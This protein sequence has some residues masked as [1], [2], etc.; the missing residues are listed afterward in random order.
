MVRRKQLRTMRIRTIKKIDYYRK[1]DSLKYDCSKFINEVCKKQWDTCKKIYMENIKKNP[2]NSNEYELRFMSDGYRGFNRKLEDGLDYFFSKKDFPMINIFTKLWDRCVKRTEDPF[3]YV[4]DPDD[5]FIDIKNR[6]LYEEED[7]NSSDDDDEEDEN[8]SDDDDEEDENSSDDDEEDFE[9]CIYK[10]KKIY[11]EKQDFLRE[12]WDEVRYFSRDLIRMRCDL[13]NNK[14][15]EILS[16]YVKC[17][18][19]LEPNGELKIPIKFSVLENQP[20][21][22]MS[23]LADFLLNHENR[24]IIKISDIADIF[25]Y[26]VCEEDWETCKIISKHRNISEHVE[27]FNSRNIDSNKWILG[28]EYFL[29]QNEPDIAQIMEELNIISNEGYDWPSDD[30]SDSDSD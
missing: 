1:F 19:Y 5:D 23:R 30:L 22:N 7:E 4:V 14:I 2:C 11:F 8:S 17:F 20:I 15:I 9:Q 10:E 28:K 6:F 18:N 16:R 25:K 27:I 12:M 24:F 3:Y 26:A 21:E 29:T 13:S